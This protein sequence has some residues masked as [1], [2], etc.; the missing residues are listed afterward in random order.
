MRLKHV[1]LAVEDELGEA[2]STQI[3]K[4]FDIEIWDTVFGEGYTYLQRK[5]MEF[6][7]SANGTAIFM[8][9]DLDS[10][11]NCPP[12]LIQSWIKG[13]LNP[14]FFFRVAVMEVE[15]WVM[16]DRDGTAS[17]LS[18]PVNR[19]PR[20][21]DEIPNPKE[22]LVSLARRSQKRTVREA[23]IPAQ[24][25]ILSVGNEYNALLSEFVQNHWNLER[26]A[27]VSPSLKRTLDR[28]AQGKNMSANQ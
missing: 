20:N 28:L 24:G 26:A 8:L 11:Q 6:N 23:L 2:V 10:P 25:A 12:R 15:S 7:R 1:I 16:A 19:I 9:T 17:F 13:A 4:R 27:S 5:A 18:I 14:Q 3:L 22:F 21:T